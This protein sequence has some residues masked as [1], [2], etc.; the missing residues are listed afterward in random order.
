MSLENNRKSVG[1]NHS[2]LSKRLR[3]LYNTSINNND[4]KDLEDNK[5]SSSNKDE[6]MLSEFFNTSNSDVHEE[7]NN[8]N[9]KHLTHEK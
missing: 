7:K 1:L 6:A 3:S 9:N 2:E 8:I 4:L 5:V